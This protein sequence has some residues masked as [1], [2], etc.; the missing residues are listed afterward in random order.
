MSLGKT[1]LIDKLMS[2]EIDPGRLARAIHEHRKELDDLLQKHPKAQE[3]E[4]G[5]MREPGSDRASLLARRILVLFRAGAR[6]FVEDRE[7]TNE[8]RSSFS[9][10]VPSLAIAS[11]DLIPGLYLNLELVDEVIALREYD[12]LEELLPTLR[13]E[14]AA[15][16]AEV[17]ASAPS[18]YS[19]GPGLIRFMDWLRNLPSAQRTRVRLT[20]DQ[21]GI[22]AAIGYSGIIVQERG[23]FLI[24]GRVLMDC[25]P[26]LVAKLFSYCLQ[27]AEINKQIRHSDSYQIFE[28]ANTCMVTGTGVDTEAF[29]NRQFQAEERRFWAES[30]N[31]EGEAM[32]LKLGGARRSGAEP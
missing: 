12:F 24:E 3:G 22:F 18:D 27:E 10:A 19:D 9:R 25:L 26:A 11:P 6:R 30:F 28:K 21:R 15:V 32:R 16:E 5:G 4:Q 29:F 20:K 13:R 8:L 31:K 14:A 23:E 17:T 2:A 7:I 1:A